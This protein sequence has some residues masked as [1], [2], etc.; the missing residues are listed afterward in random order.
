VETRH[1]LVADQLH[2]CS[3]TCGRPSVFQY[4]KPPPGSDPAT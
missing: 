4:E 2:H 1:F 3:T